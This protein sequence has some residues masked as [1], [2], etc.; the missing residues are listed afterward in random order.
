MPCAYRCSVP[1]V[2]ASAEK[3]KCVAMSENLEDNV[4]TWTAVTIHFNLKGL[5]TLKQRT[6]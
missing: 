4:A 6:K 3:G 2:G 5:H 1:V